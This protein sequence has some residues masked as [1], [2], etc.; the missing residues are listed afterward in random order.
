MLVLT[1]RKDSC[2][3]SDG[4]FRLINGDGNLAYNDMMADKDHGK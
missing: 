2:H 4:C 1:K 3:L